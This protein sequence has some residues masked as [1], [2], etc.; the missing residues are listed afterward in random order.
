LRGK[1]TPATI[2]H[3]LFKHN[4]ERAFLIRK[5]TFGKNNRFWIIPTVFKELKLFCTKSLE[6]AQKGTLKMYFMCKARRY[7]VTTLRRYGDWGL[8]QK[9]GFGLSFWADGLLFG[10]NELGLLGKPIDDCFKAAFRE[11][12]Q[13][14]SPLDA[15]TLL[16]ASGNLTEF[17]TEGKKKG[18]F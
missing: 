2:F 12:L 1:L 4:S 6:A 14:I 10:L 3:Q 9:S 8:P 13:L 15:G 11:V 16:I 7:D 18:S 5:Q 17:G